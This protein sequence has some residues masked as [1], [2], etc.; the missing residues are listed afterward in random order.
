M[1]VHWHSMQDMQHV[2][3]ILHFSAF[4]YYYL[5]FSQILKATGKLRL[6]EGIESFVI[7]H[8]TPLYGN[9]R[10]ALPTKAL[11]STP[12]ATVVKS[13]EELSNNLSSMP[14][15]K[16]YTCVGFKFEIDMWLFFK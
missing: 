10:C 6:F 9:S 8:V 16:V 5:L 2:P 1:P 12:E 7:S 3:R 4:H 13:L 14:L 15:C 11:V